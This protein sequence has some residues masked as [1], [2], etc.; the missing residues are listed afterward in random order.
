[1]SRVGGA[2]PLRTAPERAFV[3]NVYDAA[4]SELEA[5][6]RAGSCPARQ[7]RSRAARGCQ[8]GSHRPPAVSAPFLSGEGGFDSAGRPA[9]APNP[10]LQSRSSRGKNCDAAATHQI[11]T[12]L[13]WIGQQ[14]AK[15]FGE[16][17]KGCAMSDHLSSSSTEVRDRGTRGASRRRARGAGC[18]NA[19]RLVPPGSRRR[20]PLSPAPRRSLTRAT[21]RSLMTRSMSGAGSHPRPR[22]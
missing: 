7:R 4:S 18:S 8:A 1:V 5:R 14:R 16:E 12:S 17:A 15:A 2:R 19:R 21:T 22:R 3:L 20:A 9:V 6:S 13:A 11:G 10:A